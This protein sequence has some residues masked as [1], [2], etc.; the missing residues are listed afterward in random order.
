MPVELSASP[1]RSPEGTLFGILYVFRETPERERVQSALQR[2]LLE[3]A[4][5]QKRVLPSR[6][7][8][9]P[10]IRYD[11]LFLP[12]G[13]GGGDALGCFR[14][15]D[16][17]VGFYALDVIGQGILSALFSV[18]LHTF[19]SPHADRGGML[20]EKIC[21]EPRRRILSPAEAVRELNRRF[22]LR[23]EGNPYFTIAYGVL[24]PSTGTMRISRAGHPYPLLQKA[25]GEVHWVKPEGYAVG[26][27]PTAEVASEELS[28]KQGDRLFLYSDGLVD[29]TNADGVRFSSTRLAELV[30]A[31]SGLPLADV[32]ATLRDAVTAWRGSESFA[33]DVSLIVL[34]KE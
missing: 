26:L 5:V 1:L 18:L 15:D 6:E 22:F 10:G 19:L 3:L 12:A 31:G 30:T 7:T 4:R 32:I 14:L 24:E 16:G 33:D 8:V 11:W 20:V 29:C 27:F 17:H 25:N 21:E 13:L 9:V 23:D 2:D 28:L 34:E